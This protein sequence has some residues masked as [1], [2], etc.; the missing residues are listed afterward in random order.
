MMKDL[1]VNLKKKNRC[2]VLNVV[3]MMIDIEQLLL[4]APWSDGGP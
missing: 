1:D 4:C 3:H 2:V